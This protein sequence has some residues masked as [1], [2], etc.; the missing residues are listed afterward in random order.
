MTNLIGKR[1]KIK[2]KREN[3]FRNGILEKIDTYI[4]GGLDCGE[5]EAIFLKQPKKTLVI[6]RSEI[7]IIK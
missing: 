7:E 4:F 5:Y 1:V 2:I 3:K 6:K